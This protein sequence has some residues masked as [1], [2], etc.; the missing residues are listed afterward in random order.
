MG[1]KESTECM[2]EYGTEDVENVENFI[3]KDTESKPRPLIKSKKRAFKDAYFDDDSAT[4][5][6][7]PTLWMP[8]WIRSCI[9]AC[10]R[11][12]MERITSAILTDILETVLEPAALVDCFNL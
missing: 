3:L 9:A 7:K 12:R 4:K 8:N 6:K 10:S 5:S 2:R 1:G 11:W